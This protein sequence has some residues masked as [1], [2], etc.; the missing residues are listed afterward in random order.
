MNNNNYL[1]EFNKW[2]NNPTID[3]ETKEQLLKLN[4]DEIEDCF[5]TNISFGTAGM[6]GIIG[7]GPNRFNK[8][9]LRRA[10]Y[11]YGK[12]LCRNN[13]KNISVVIARDN[14]FMGKEFV[15]ECVKVLSMFGIKCYVFE[16][17][18]P[19]PTLSFAIRYLKADGGIVITASHNPKDYNGYKIYDN[20]GCQLVPELASIVVE[21]VK[22]APNYFDIPFMEFSDCI[23]KD[24]YSK[25]DECV[26]EEYIKNVESIL[27]NKNINKSNFRLT[28]SPLH[29]T[30]GVIGCKLLDKLGY[31]YVRVEQQ[32]D[33]DCS[34]PTVVY[35]NPEDKKALDLSLKYAI[36]YNCDICLAT[37]PDADRIGVAVKDVDGQ[38]KFLNGNEMGA[39]LV[40]YIC[41]QINVNDCY[42]IDTI[43]TSKL[44]KEIA[45]KNGANVIS[46][47][48]G[49]KFI[50]QQIDYLTKNNKKFIFGYEESYGYCLKGFVR[51]KDALQALVFISEV[52]CYYKN[53]NKNLIQV[54]DEIRKKYGYHQ[55]GLISLTLN[56]SK[57]Q[58]QIKNVLKHF[59]DNNFNYINKYKVINKIDY[60]ANDLIINN[61][62]LGKSDV[63]TFEFE[64]NK[65]VIF[66][67]SGTEPKLKAYLGIKAMSAEDVSTL[68]C[69]FKQLI[70]EEINK[71]I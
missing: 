9:T 37:D 56:G 46:T 16:E 3:C 23:K 27:I 42:V 24:F 48:T 67:P 6:R 5:Y 71:L 62:N 19:T 36:D 30:A 12:F 53:K 40:D 38:F 26:V 17:I 10:N 54:L 57:G 68:M 32:F 15:E 18:T 29:G 69:E 51:D 45:L 65:Y 70:S 39:I 43:V 20:T 7:V 47:Y 25:V 28:F 44:G 55:E 4:D 49:F 63:I 11:G 13:K 58:E 8:Y 41:N 22:N 34:F 1:N 2:V 59:R 35:P 14:R 33:N 60:L 21:N 64:D 31:D 66:R 50:A 61:I 52:A